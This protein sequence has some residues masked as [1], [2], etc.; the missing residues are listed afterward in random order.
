MRAV[1]LLFEFEGR[2]KGR[3]LARQLIGDPHRRPHFIQRP[4]LTVAEIITTEDID[5]R[6]MSV[7]L[8]ASRAGG[9]GGW[10]VG[11]ARRAGRRGAAIGA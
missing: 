6:R 10:A 3:L 8:I 9:R 5:I 1:L 2:I 11:P 7:A 4:R